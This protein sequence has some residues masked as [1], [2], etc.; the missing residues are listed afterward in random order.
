MKL[1]DLQKAGAFVSTEAVEAPVEW[2]GHTFTVNVRKV[3]FGD[4]ESLIR[5]GDDDSQSAKL[6]S[7]T[8]YLPDQKRFMTYEEAYQLKASFAAALMK[9]VKAACRLDD[10]KD[11]TPPTSSGTN[12]PSPSDAPSVS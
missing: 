9:A 4:Y 10:P 6:L 5:M 7:K 1:A 2:E 12:S 11:S 3:S 8:V